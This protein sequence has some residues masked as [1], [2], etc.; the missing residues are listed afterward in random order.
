[1]R[2]EASYESCRVAMTNWE[3][4]AKI[5]EQA[6]LGVETAKDTRL[7]AQNVVTYRGAVATLKQLIHLP[8][9][10]S[11]TARLHALSIYL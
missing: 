9:Y 10:T 8:I 11:I 5:A 7:R 4:E 1:M 3:L 6:S 2:G